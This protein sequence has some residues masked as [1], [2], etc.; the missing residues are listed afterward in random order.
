MTSPR[1][2]AH[3]IK[4]PPTPEEAAAIMAAVGR[5]MRATAALAPPPGKTAS[6]DRWREEA[7]VEGVQREDAHTALVDPWINT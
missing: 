4:P 3:A 5:F 1:P 6:E 7:L 2:T